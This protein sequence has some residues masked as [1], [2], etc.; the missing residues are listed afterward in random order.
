MNQTQG[1]QLL[2]KP[3]D[4]FE[5]KYLIERLIG[6]GGMGAVFAANHIG[7]RQRVA[8]KFLIGE[9]L[10]NQDS[11]RRFHTEAQNAA[12]IRSEYVAQV[13]DVA[14]SHAGL[15]Y[16]VMEYLDGCDLAQLID[17]RAAPLP[18]EEA[19]DY[20]LQALEG[21]NLAHAQGIVHRD[22]KPSNLFL[23]KRADGQTVVKVLD[24]GIS[25]AQ[26][27]G[28]GAAVGAVTSTKAMLGSPLYMSP[29]QLR[30]SR[31][32][33]ARADVWAVGVIL[34]ELLTRQLPFLGENLGELFAAILETEAAP[35]R[36]HNPA[37]PQAL[38]PVVHRCLAKN[39]DQRW[40][41]VAELARALAPFASP[42]SQGLS[43]LA[44]A[45]TGA[46]SPY[47]FTNVPSGAIPLTTP[48][49]GMGHG[50]RTSDP[51][52]NPRVSGVPHH[53]ASTGSAANVAIPVLTQG[54]GANPSWDVPKKSNAGLVA[55]LVG[56]LVVVGAAGGGIAVYKQKQR[57]AAEAAAPPSAIAS[58]SAKP[59][60]S[61]SAATAD[62]APV[63]L[64]SASTAPSASAA[65]TST[66]ASV[67]PT[68]T[69][70]GKRV[71]PPA[72][73]AATGAAT[74]PTALTVA[75]TPPPPTV[76]APPATAAPT[77]TGTG[78]GRVD[79]GKTGRD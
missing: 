75:T 56:V 79:P 44:G 15:P 38:E 45:R 59:V 60:A 46:G 13:T 72:T 19:I 39:R 6:Q 1:R 41:N 73:G 54:S 47:A 35:L 24:F 61:V 74:T 3:G 8:I 52:L 51:S 55:A 77:G 27:Q 11:V 67:A 31:S 4:V 12:T 43:I 58:D 36:K 17:Q 33:D 50:G 28:L 29:E 7:L 65:P 16:M 70:G 14:T 26:N 49:P 76:T 20:V 64:G 9:A 66:H 63:A 78:K 69:G 32:V 53:H 23:A 40:P 30:S 42:R 5:G 62:T 10:G 68:A 25:K 71:P 2:P 57:A 37:L 48:S 21:I 34:Y 22:L 18:V